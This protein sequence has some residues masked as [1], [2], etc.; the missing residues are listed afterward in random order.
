[1]FLNVGITIPSG[2]LKNLKDV[3]NGHP[4]ASVFQ[5]WEYQ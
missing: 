2:R 3:D 4:W 5:L 1:M